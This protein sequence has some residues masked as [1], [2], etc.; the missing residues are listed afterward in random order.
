MAEPTLVLQ[1]LIRARLIA[2]AGVTDLVPAGSIVSQPRK[3]DPSPV[4]IIGEGHAFLADLDD[5]FHDE[6]FV[7]VDAWAREDTTTGVKNIASA[8]RQALRDRPWTMPGYLC[9][10]LRIE[11]VEFRREGEFARG[12]VTVSAIM[13]EHAPA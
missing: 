5:T 1:R 13:Q 7:I 12:I 6:A 11:G 8:I 2:D 9:H 3:P 10:R 4:I